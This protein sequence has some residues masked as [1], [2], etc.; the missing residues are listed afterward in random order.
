MA[1]CCNQ[2]L[3]KKGLVPKDIYADTVAIIGDDAPFFST[4]QKWVAE[5]KR[6]S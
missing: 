4:V 1:P 5:F 3:Q 6:G 2:N